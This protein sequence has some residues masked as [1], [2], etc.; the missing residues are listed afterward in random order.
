MSTYNA[1]APPTQLEEDNEKKKDGQGEIELNLSEESDDEQVGKAAPVSAKAA[2]RMARLAALKAKRVRGVCVY[3]CV[4]VC[5]YAFVRL[6]VCAWVSVNEVVCVC[7]S[8][9]VSTCKGRSRFFRH[10]RLHQPPFSLCYPCEP[11]FRMDATWGL[12]SI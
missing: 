12:Q 3:V 10:S 1:V 9:C 4:C 7:V 6:C 8:V 2:E 5:V 11:C